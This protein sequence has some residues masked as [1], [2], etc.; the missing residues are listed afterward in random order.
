MRVV[1]PRMKRGSMKRVRRWALA[2]VLAATV[3]VS[4]CESDAF[5]PDSR[6]D[7]RELEASYEW[8]LENWTD[9]EPVGYP[10]V[11]LTWEVPERHRNEPFRVY[12]A[13]GNGSYGLIATVTSCSDGI[14]RYADT[15][16]IHGRTYYYQVV[17]LDERGGDEIGFS[18]EVQV[19]V[20][21][22]PA[23]TTPA[24]PAVTGLDGAVFLEW[25]ATGAIAYRIL[26]EPDGEDVFLIGE[27]D[28]TSFLD[29]R[30][31]N[32]VRYDYYLAAVD[33]NGHVSELSPAARGIPRPDF[34]AD[35]V[36][37][38]ADRSS[39][40]GFRFVGDEASDPVLAGDSPNAQWRLEAAGGALRIRPLGQTAITAGTFTTALTCGPGSEANCVD[41]RTAP[42]S[43][44]FGT[45]AVDAEAGN[46]YVL[47]VV[48]D[49][50]QTHYG[51]VRV[52]GSTVDSSGRRLIIFDWAYQLRANEPSLQRWIR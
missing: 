34:H 25:E 28:G 3:G 40:S 24:A 16:V 41:V 37:A 19:Q 12:A 11:H 42:A 36:Y 45:A 38:H 4:A 49:D 43:S 21:N 17:T 31:E 14:C 5:G 48:G 26:V 27:T 46:T 52:Q 10:V 29:D 32:G 44:A 8:V 9:G 20:P 6:Y 18:R 22:A 13:Y 47:R 23:L 51:K 7:P 50:G 30:A 35:I 15:N 1:L 39:A 2:P 33:A